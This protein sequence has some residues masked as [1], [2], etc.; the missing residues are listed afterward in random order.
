MVVDQENVSKIL[1]V[2]SHKIRREV[3]RILREKGESSFTDLMNS[4]NLDTGTLSFHMRSLAVFV[5]QTDSGKYKLSRI[6]ENALRIIRDVESW[7]EAADVSRKSSQLPLASFGKRAAA[8]LLDYGIM[9]GLSTLLLLVEIVS[10]TQVT[11]A[12]LALNLLAVAFGLL[13]AYSTLLEGFN[14][15]S[16][17]KMALG[18]KVVQIDDKKLS[19]EHA[20]IRNF[21]KIFLPLDLIFGYN[22]PRFVRFFDKFAGTTVI[23][24]RK[25]KSSQEP[26]NSS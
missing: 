12:V 18:L 17:G 21:G 10:I 8:F 13:W 1:S 2:L 6:G 11:F 25:R 24:L 3:L 16:I 14:G 15:Q 19:Y 22:D 20:A 26:A 7:S 4:L 23:D 5:E 9:L